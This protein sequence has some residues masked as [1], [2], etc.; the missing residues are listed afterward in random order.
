MSNQVKGVCSYL[1]PHPPIF[2]NIM[3]ILVPEI[4]SYLQGSMCEF[5]VPTLCSLGEIREKTF[6]K[7]RKGGNHHFIKQ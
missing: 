1:Q 5:H 4:E 2:S 7:I 6:L 3:E